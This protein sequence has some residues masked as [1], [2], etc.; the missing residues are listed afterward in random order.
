[1]AISAWWRRRW[2]RYLTEALVFVAIFAAIATWQKRHMAE[3]PAPTLVATTLAG[4]PFDLH[5]PR[6]GPVLV[7]FW[8][9]WCPVCKAEEGTIEALAADPERRVITIAMESGD[10]A[11]VR[12]H[13]A[14]RGLELPVIVDEQGRLAAAW[15]VRGVP[16]TFVVDAT[17]A[18]RFREMGYTTGPGLRLRLWWAE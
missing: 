15:G 10:A 16:A 11:E 18:I 3:G 14:E 5:A 13:L 1:M 8:A 9:S 6:A 17:N 4:D 12:A 7:H 2:V